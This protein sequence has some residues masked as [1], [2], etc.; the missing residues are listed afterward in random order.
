MKSTPK[1]GTGETSMELTSFHGTRTST[2]LNTVVPAGLKDLP[3]LLL[4]DST[5]YWE[6]RTPPLL[7]CPPKSWLTA[8]PVAHAMEETHQECTTG[9][10]TMVSLTPAASNIRL[11]T[12]NLIA[13]TPLTSAETAPGLPLLPTR[14]A[15]RAA[16][17]LTTR[18]T[19]S[20]TTT[21]SQGLPR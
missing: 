21:D 17:L 14:L 9:P 10:T 13:A 3:Q 20:L 2:F 6:I 11:G 8:K 18:S 7:L 1:T 16:G 15:L 4:I 19:T 12:L 5:F